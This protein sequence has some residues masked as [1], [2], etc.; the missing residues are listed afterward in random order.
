[1]DSALKTLKQESE[2]G[3]ERP[4]PDFAQLAQLAKEISEAD[5]TYVLCVD[6]D[7]TELPLFEAY[8]HWLTGILPFYG[9]THGRTFGFVQEV[10]KKARVRL[11]VFITQQTPDAAWMREYLALSHQER[12]NQVL[13]TL[14]EVT[15]SLREWTAQDVDNTKK[16]HQDAWA[17][18]RSTLVTLP[19]Q[20]ETMFAEA[21]GVRKVFIAP[22]GSYKVIGA[23]TK[24]Y[25]VNN[26][27]RLLGAL[28]SERLPA[29]DLRILCGG[30]GSGKSTV[31][32]MLA[33]ELA[34]DESLHP[35]FLRLRRMK[36]GA[37]ISAYVEESLRKEGLIDRL[38]DLRDLPNL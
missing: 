36:E 35:I 27:P 17:D 19:D 11:K 33:S 31:C 12:T 26:V 21:F 5:A 29:G 1:L 32:R 10:S 22:Q 23:T 25:E 34:K 20:P 37:D 9:V 24:S 38:S 14:A 2:K 15:T 4:E 30:P 7:K 18:Y 8:D 6:P 3:S 13:T 28:L 16:R